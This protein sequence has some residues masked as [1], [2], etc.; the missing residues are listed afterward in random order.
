MVPLEVSR[1]PRRMNNYLWTAGKFIGAV[2]KG[3]SV[4]EE[5]EDFF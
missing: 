4:H 3:Q 5:T 1:S 2:F